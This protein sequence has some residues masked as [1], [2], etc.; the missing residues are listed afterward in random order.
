MLKP[1]LKGHFGIAGPW[2][3]TLGL[4]MLDVDVSPPANHD[5][6]WNYGLVSQKK[7]ITLRTLHFPE[8]PL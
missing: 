6:R 5:H 1:A 7:S 2:A 4:E 8:P 3:W